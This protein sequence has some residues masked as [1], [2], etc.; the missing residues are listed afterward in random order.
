MH[1]V[2][3]SGR[4]LFAD[5]VLVTVVGQ[6]SRPCCTV[7]IQSH[8]E[9]VSCDGQCGDKSVGCTLKWRSKSSDLNACKHAVYNIHMWFESMKRKIEDGLD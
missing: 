7:T 3:A 6:T 5:T 9:H 8:V 2:E 4:T 1:R